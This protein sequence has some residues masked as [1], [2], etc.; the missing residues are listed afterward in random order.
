MVRISA[1]E[2]VI[3]SQYRRATFH[4]VAIAVLLALL[5]SGLV[6][7]LFLQIERMEQ[8]ESRLHLTQCTVDEATEYVMHRWPLNLGSSIAAQLR[9]AVRF[10]EEH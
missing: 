8:V 2:N 9:A 1:D 3:F 7:L 5:I 10:S 6:Y 4:R